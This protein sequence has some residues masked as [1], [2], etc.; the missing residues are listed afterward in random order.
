MYIDN[1]FVDCTNLCKEREPTCGGNHNFVS[2]REK[3]LSKSVQLPK[4]IL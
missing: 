3:L 4:T 2:K 1:Y